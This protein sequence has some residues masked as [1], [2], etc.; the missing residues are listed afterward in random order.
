MLMFIAIGLRIAGL[1]TK[2]F[3][4][5]E[6]ASSLLAHADWQTFA[7]ALVHRQANMALYYL[8]LRGWI[9]FG[10]TEI[11]LRLLSVAFGVITI[12]LL[13]LVAEKICGARTARLAALLMTIHV[14]HIQYSQEARAYALA[15]FLALASC[16]FFLQ[17][18][19]ESS[20][21]TLL[22]YIV[23]SL[24]MVYAHIF[25]ALILAAQWSFGLLTGP[26]KQRRHLAIAV[27]VVSLLL[28]P[29]FFCLLLLSDRS[30]L[31]WMEMSSAS[32]FYEFLWDISGRGGFSVVVLFAALLLV[33]LRAHLRS[34]NYVLKQGPSYFFLWLWL[35]VPS[36]TV[37]VFALRIP[38][39][40]SRYLIFCLPAFLI[41]AADGLASLKSRLISAAAAI[42]V[43][44]FSLLA[45]NQYYRGRIDP[46]RSDN[47]RDATQY[48]LSRVQPGDTILFPYSAEEIPFRDYARRLGNDGHIPLVP[49]QTELQLLTLPGSW[50]SPDVVS[51]TALQ[52]QRVW[53]VSALQP[54]A[55]SQA[56]VNELNTK[57]VNNSHVNFGFVRMQIFGPRE[58]SSAH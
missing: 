30:Q 21:T 37:A 42:I 49:T 48:V 22:M 44:V 16:Y 20:K 46:N 35:M 28:S 51:S 57:P 18:S 39:V 34:G 56:L 14:F 11:W 26:A 9:H 7:T 54:N 15:L 38:I 5:D 43:A 32:S 2:S 8:L 13:Y 55:H 10:D 23:T 24:L 12:P 27:V 1:G 4:L 33:S 58:L 3:W 52:H 31:S 40:Q 29:L 45:V 17:L 41:L 53:V 25:S 50:T 47:W 6:S 19:T 36:T